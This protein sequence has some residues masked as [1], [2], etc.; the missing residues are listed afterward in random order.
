MKS[1]AT[2]FVTLQWALAF[3]SL[4]TIIQTLEAELLFTNNFSLLLSAKISK[5]TALASWMW[6]VAATAGLS[7]AAVV[8]CYCKHLRFMEL[9]PPLLLLLISRRCWSR[10]VHTGPDVNVG[11]YALVDPIVQ[12]NDVGQMI[13]NSEAVISPLILE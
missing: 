11:R 6:L 2:V 13:G 10:R 8:V 1:S 4:V 12:V 5:L 7:S 3:L 9:P